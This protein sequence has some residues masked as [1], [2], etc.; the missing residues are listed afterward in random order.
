MDRPGGAG[1]SDSHDC[2]PERIL[3]NVRD[4]LVSIETARETYGVG[5]IETDYGYELNE[6]ETEALQS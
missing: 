1:F 4:D 5:V 2:D 6:R 3:R